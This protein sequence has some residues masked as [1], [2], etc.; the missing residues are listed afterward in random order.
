M[1]QK[2]KL[3]VR[4]SFL[5]KI[6]RWGSVGI[7]AVLPILYFPQRIASYVT[8]KQYFFIGAVDILA[9]FWVWLLISD[10]RYRLAKKGM[11]L[12]LP[13]LLFLISLT[14]SAFTGIDP[15]TSFYSTVESGTGLIL[16]Y[17]VFLFACI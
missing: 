10:K 16:L 12:L 6:V 15:K 14:V 13:L 3:I 17:H 2:G 11:V 7:F 1:A 5:E 8:S 4:E 9:I